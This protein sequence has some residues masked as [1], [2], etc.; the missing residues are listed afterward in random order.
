MKLVRYHHPLAGNFS[1]L[2]RWFRSPSDGFG[3][4]FELAERL[5]GA[6]TD[7]ASN[8]GADLYEDEDHYYARLELPG[9]KKADLK[10]ELH[11]HQLSVSYERQNGEPK[12]ADQPRETAVSKRIVTVPDG[13]DSEKVSAKLEDGILTITLPKSVERKPREIKVA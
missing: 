3:R 10:L 4:L 9:V 6:P 12:K 8:Y 13:I 11:D 5:S 1:D 2:D 7:G